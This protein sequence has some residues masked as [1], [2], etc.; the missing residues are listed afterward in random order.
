A[1]R[2]LF[3]LCRRLSCRG[4]GQGRSGAG[5]VIVGRHLGIADA[6]I[7]GGVL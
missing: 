6:I 5:C 3:F 7:F 1:H 4:F 2:S